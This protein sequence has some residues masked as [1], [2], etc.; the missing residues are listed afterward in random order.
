MITMVIFRDARKRLLY[1]GVIFF[2]GFGFFVAGDFLT[3]T[4]GTSLVYQPE[5]QASIVIYLQGEGNVELTG[6]SAEVPLV[7]VSQGKMPKFKE[8]HYNNP[9]FFTDEEWRH[10]QEANLHKGKLRVLG[11]EELREN[12][13][14]KI[15][16]FRI[17]VEAKIP[18]GNSEEIQE[19]IIRLV[20]DGYNIV[21]L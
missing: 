12:Q 10:W 2:F 16:V 4:T 8:A 17:I 21:K 19:I 18:P 5:K 7:V 15:N 11:V 20:E 1:Y 6:L 14:S 13:R 3:V 9:Q